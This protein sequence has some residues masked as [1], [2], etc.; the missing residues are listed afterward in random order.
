MDRGS[1]A[2]RI[3]HT[4]LDPGATDAEVEAH[5]REAVE[6]GCLGVCVH[7]ARLPAARA[8]LAGSG[9]LAVAVVD[10][11]HG[12]GGAR[13]KAFACGEAA[14][15]GADEIDTVLDAGLARAGRWSE[16]AA[17][18]RGAVEAAGAAAVKVILETSR[19]AEPEKIRA[20]EA[21]VAAGAAFVKTSTGFGPGGA[22][23]A[24]VRLLSRVAAGRIQV[25][26]A[27]GI[28]CADQAL[29]LVRAGAARL[30]MSRSRAV[31]AGA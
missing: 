25:K 23:V 26:A 27:G 2:S 17:E 24:D 8:A 28:A 11:P 4:L 29:A 14:A 5:C 18:L 7:L 21:A 20:L 15:L 16:L 1:L 22:T 13:V 19:L 3:E 9:L 30:G 12:L 31:L 6:L 10:F